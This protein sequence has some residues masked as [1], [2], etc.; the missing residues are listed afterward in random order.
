MGGA[1]GRA[2]LQGWGPGVLDW[3]T[4]S[5]PLS[6]LKEPGARLEALQQV[7]SRLPQENLDNLR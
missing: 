6:S 1:A 5:L 2:G 3:L 4:R 7:C